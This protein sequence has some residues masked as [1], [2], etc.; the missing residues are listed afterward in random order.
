MRNTVV[1]LFVVCLGLAFAKAQPTS[2][3]PVS[4]DTVITPEY[5]YIDGDSVSNIELNEIRL[6][7]S[8]KFDHTYERLKYQYL[9]RKVR[10][11]WPYARMAAQRLEVLNAD[12]EQFDKKRHKRQYTRKLQDSL[13][14]E[15]TADLKKLTTTEGKILIKLIHRQTG[16]TAFELM[17]N[18]RSGWKAFWMNNTARL[19]DLNLKATYNPETSVQDFYI[20]D[21]LLNEFKHESLK[22]QSA[23]ITYD[24]YKGKTHWKKYEDALPKDY[25]SVNLAARAQRIQKYSEK[26]A[27]KKERARKKAARKARR[28]ERREKKK[29]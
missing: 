9:K 23:A 27:R 1:L 5:F 6:L 4:K 29:A 28:E 14:N 22:E 24:Y 12:L 25:D 26:K 10:K 20:E 11:V 7:R 8:L 16:V 2:T 15:L 3:L 13:E 18:L 17:K 21:I 19:F